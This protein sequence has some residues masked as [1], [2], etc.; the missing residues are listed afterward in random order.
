LCSNHPVDE[1]IFKKK[2]YLQKCG[3]Q[4]YQSRES[5]SQKGINSSAPVVKYTLQNLIM[6][7]ECGFFIVRNLQ[8]PTYSKKKVSKA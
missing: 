7:D 2:Y 1:D 5:S 6:P 4:Q 8:K 3:I